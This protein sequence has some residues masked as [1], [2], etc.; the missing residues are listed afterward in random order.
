[1]HLIESKEIKPYEFKKSIDEI[2]EEKEFKEIESI[3][4]FLS[5][6]IEEKYLK[7]GKMLLSA[8]AHISRDDFEGA[9]QKL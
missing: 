3:F 6:K 5:K 1:M 4:L 8:A 7:E 9:I 2:Q